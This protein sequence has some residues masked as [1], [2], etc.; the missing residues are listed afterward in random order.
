MAGAKKFGTF[1]GVFTP[2]ILTILGVIMYLRLGWVVGEAGLYSAL[3]LIFIAHI[4]SVSTG[5]SLSSIATDKKIK[6]GGI[7]YMLSRSLG[8]PMGGSIGITLFLGTALSISLYIVGFVENFLSIES[9]QAFLNMSGT[10]NDIR[11]IG[12]FVII[13]LVLLAYISTSI[14][15]KTQFFI[16]G[17]IALSLVS[18]V[19]GIFMAPDI[20]AAAPALMPSD[21]SPD[22]IVIFA[23]FFPAVTGFTAGVAMSGDLKSPKDSIPK[24][25]LISI[26]VGLAV[27]VGL[28]LL[29]AFYVDR[30]LLLYDTNFLQKIAWSSPLVIAGIWG[31]T[32]S[33]AIGGILGAPRI[34]QAMSSD[35]VTH[36]FFAKGVGGNNEPRRALILTFLLAEIG[37][38]IGELD[39]IAG[40]VSMFYI[41]AYGFINLAYVLERWANS[42][43]RP[44]M[45]ISIWVGIIGFVASMG[46]MFKLDTV[47]MFIAFSIMFGIYVF[48]KRK[49][50][51]G[52]ISDVWQSVWTSIIRTSLH[53]V[54]KKP[55]KESNW[56]PNI[57]LFSGGGSARPYLL[58]FGVNIAGNQGFL[59]NFDLHIKSDAV[60]FS[61]ADQKVTTEID[62]KYTGVFTRKQSV[63][64][65][66]EG[67]EIISQTYG[68]SGVEPNTIMMGWARQSSNPKR[69]SE[70]IFNL[71][72]L[73]MN[74]VMLDYDKERRWGKKQTID[75]WWRG[76][77]N[78]GNFSLSL[79]KFMTSSDEWENAKI[80]L[81]VI[82]QNVDHQ[83]AIYERAALVLENLRINAELRIIDNEIEQRSFYDI[84]KLE[85]IDTDLIFL[86]LTEIEK[87]KEI[88]FVQQTNDL[89]RDI[90]TVAIIKA[91]SQFQDLSLID[92][93]DIATRSDKKII[94]EGI[95]TNVSIKHLSQGISNHALASEMAP[96]I[97][98][99]DVLNDKL[100]SSIIHPVFDSQNAYLLQMRDHALKSFDNLISRAPK[101]SDSVFKKAI[102]LQHKFFIRTQLKYVED[103]SVEP[104]VKV[105]DH[106]LE[107]IVSDIVDFTKDIFKYSYRVKV[108]LDKSRYQAFL[109]ENKKFKWDLYPLKGLFL[110]SD[111]IPYYVH[112]RELV[113]NHYP[114]SVY[115]VINRLVIMINK[116]NFKFENDLFKV[117]RRISSVYDNSLSESATSVP[118]VEM[119]RKEQE[120]IRGFI[121][122]MLQI[123]QQEQTT[124]IEGLKMLFVDDMNH[125]MNQ[126]NAPT[127]NLYINH[128]SDFKAIIKTK[129]KK[130]RLSVDTM[131]ANTDLLNHVN[132]LNT[133]LLSFRFITLNELNSL[134]LSLNRV[135]EENF[136]KPLKEFLQILK[137]L[138]DNQDSISIETIAEKVKD[139]KFKSD[140][141]IQQAFVDQYNYSFKKIKD[142]VLRFPEQLTI[143]TDS[144]MFIKK[145][146]D[147]YPLQR[148]DVS[149]RRTVSFMVE[150][151]MIE[152]QESLFKKGQEFN[153]L[154][155]ELSEI[156]QSIGLYASKSSDF[157]SSLIESKES[158]LTEVEF[159]NLLYDRVLSSEGVIKEKQ[160]SIKALLLKREENIKSNSELYPFIRNIQDVKQYIKEEKKKNWF[161]KIFK[162]QEFVV[163]AIER[164]INRLW[165]NQSSGILL[166]QKFSK[167]IL[168]PETRVET[169]L[170]F[171]EEISPSATVLNKI[172]DYYKQLFLRKHFYLNEFWVGRD[173]ELNVF[174][175]SFK[176]WESGYSGGIMIVGERNSGKSFFANYVSQKFE[177]SGETYFINPPYEGSVAISDLLQN[178]QQATETNGS[179]S[180]ILNSIPAKS[181][182]FI[183]DL[184][185]WW[186][187]SAEGM[188]VIKQLIKLING[189]GHRHLFVFMANIHSFN[190]INKYKKIDSNFLSLIELLPFNAHELKDI[191]MR[192]HQTSS[193]SFKIDNTSENKFRSWNYARLF[194]GYFKYSEG[195]AG[196]ALQAWI[197]SVKDI[198]DTTL[199]LEKPKNLDIS[200]LTFIET[201]WMIFLMQF[202]L[203]KR[204]TRAKLVRVSHENRLEVIKKLRVLKR[205]GLVVSL[206]DDV[207]ELDTHLLAFIRKAL[208]KQELL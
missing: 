75:I 39:V 98:D 9:I 13:I 38:L 127:P 80:R 185:L 152:I 55:L 173:T 195:N 79:A 43:F 187:K 120:K 170:G 6:T 141:R 76:G 61:K 153:V 154:Q 20:Q 191:V 35:K 202:I 123:R 184:E 66:Y 99:L 149:L 156:V 4:I 33:S 88:E 94:V 15:I 81:L 67:I 196:V 128:S 73:D 41:A 71:T 178:F 126:L 194:N 192:R 111:K 52:N 172:P 16:L 32:L 34:L 23:V 19:A 146:V 58:E 29:L 140:L 129:N 181:I 183:D 112:L 160:D 114:Q 159:I 168:D 68:F 103:I 122:E 117:I 188:N 49:E 151:A 53:N 207:F 157:N 72:K 130:L 50:V 169:L 148:I 60:Y 26:A 102:A 190:L 137:T 175:K 92:K 109:A 45:K 18:I 200:L 144:N 46:V 150:R 56:Q 3:A 197:S 51:D 199:L 74:I 90:G 164:Y 163:D 91:S 77:G 118:S 162:R 189:F 22:L 113:M 107:P 131:L 110:F 198:N 139:I 186:E 96:L 8:L 78:N 204:M 100:V 201:D 82:N 176:Q 64:N 133:Y 208:V 17:A 62:E 25:T 177:T 116:D 182:F 93:K 147:M 10:V 27:Y 136:V 54:N 37:I 14:A 7:Y 21:G 206:G 36:K 108:T 31:A 95:N 40:I 174:E 142:S 5:L 145:E 65:L 83:A 125:F 158:K 124:M 87:G 121:D 44:S 70:M 143:Y 193:L 104:A 135:V 12:T 138:V 134:S 132:Q 101:N 119:L 205:A 105:F 28:A 179:F 155:S 115:Q 48:L 203:H 42:D 47:G 30:E 97:D 2:S 84:I 63:S 166:A 59:S 171:K 86:G 57:I 89:C 106:Q 161:N 85:S 24:G 1:A 11:L 180:Q 69:F 167:A 165:Y